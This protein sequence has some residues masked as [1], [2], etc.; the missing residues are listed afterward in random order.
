MESKTF[1]K[2]RADRGLLEGVIKLFQIT[3]GVVIKGQ[4]ME[5]LIMFMTPSLNLVKY[6]K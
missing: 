2:G 5:I 4:N 1:P 6:L 3:E